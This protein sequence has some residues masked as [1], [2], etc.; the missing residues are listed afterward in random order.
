MTLRFSDVR[1]QVE[2]LGIAERFFDSALLFALHELR[3]VPA[4]A[5]GPREL[6]ALAAHIGGDPRA[7][8]AVLDGA[9]AVGLLTRETD[10]YGAPPALRACLGR[11]DD[12]AYLG[13]WITFLGALAGPV[14]HLAE[15]VRTGR[16]AGSMIDGTRDD[17][18]AR[19]MTAAMDAYARTR[20]AE[21]VDVLDVRGVTTLLDVGCGPGTYSL[22]LLERHPTLNAI[23]LDLPGPIE[24]ARDA[25]TS[26]GLGERVRLVAADA[27][28]YTPERPVDLVLVSNV[29]HMLGPEL[30]PRLLAR[31]AAHLAPGGRLIV[32]AEFLGPERTAPRWP[33]LLN[34]IMAATTESGRNHDVA[35]TRAWMEAAGLVDVTHRKLSPWNVNSL[36]VGNRPHPG[37]TP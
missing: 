32:Q 29:L 31:C 11:P 12:P 20:G 14:G 28:T 33:A 30:S 22:A 25:V 16:P 36:L 1:K 4:L 24:R 26:R 2:V 34:V 8:S 23:L 35:E 19:A 9:V 18:P 3:V 17:R 37:T 7:L 6:A 21:F 5:D 10:G 13:E 15:S 27:L